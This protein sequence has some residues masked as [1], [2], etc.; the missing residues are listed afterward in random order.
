[1]NEMSL[2]GLKISDQRGQ[3]ITGSK[4]I[5]PCRDQHIHQFGQLIGAARTSIQDIPMPIYIYIPVPPE[6][7]RLLLP[8]H[9][10]EPKSLTAAH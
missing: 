9:G 1:M 10:N 4:F 7:N 6:S 5:S 8:T 2:E 3:F